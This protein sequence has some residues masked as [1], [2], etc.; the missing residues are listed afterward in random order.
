MIPA[1]VLTLP[2]LRQELE[3]L[4]RREHR[5]KL[6]ALF[7]RGEAAEF[8]LNGQRW[9]VLPTQCELE[10]RESLP[11]PDEEHVEGRVFLVDWTS[12][13]LPLDV[14]CRLAGGRLYHVARDARLAA[15]FGARQVEPGLAG[16]ALA[17][18]YLSGVLPP[19]RKV[20]GLRLTLAA[21]WASLLEGRLR[22][23]ESALGSAGTLL[24]WASFND[25]GP[26]F[27]RLCE[28]DELWRKLRRELTDWLRAT[29]GE[30]TVVVWQSWEQGLAPRLLESLVLLGAARAAGEAYLSGLL[31]GQLSAWLP[32][33]AVAVRGVESVLADEKTLDTALPSERPLLLSTLE[34]SEAL[35]ESAGLGALTVSS[36]RLP[37]G[38]RARERELARATLACVEAPSSDAARTV[39]EA[40]KRLE[41]HT[42]D[43]HLRPEE[44]RSARKNLGRMALWLASRDTGAPAGSR[45]QA[46]VELARAYAE[47]GGYVEW[48]RQQL[49]GLRGA[50]ETLLS[51]AR[52]LELAAAAALR[53][54]HRSFAEAY[55]AWMEARKPSA[56][57]LPIEDIGKHLILPFLEG[58]ERRKLLVVLMDGMSHAVAVQILSRLGNAR[59]WGPIAWRKDRWHGVLPLPPVLAVAPTL[60]PLSRGAFFAGKAD[61]RMGDE[62]TD[63][64]PARW[65]AHRALGK[66]FGDDAPPLFVRRDL[67]SGHELAADLR[68]AI[69]GDCRAVAVVVNAVDEDL[70]SS[71]QVAKDYSLAP[72]LPLEALLTAAEEGERAVLLVSDH[73]HVLGDGALTLEGRLSQARA[74]GARWRALAEGEQPEAEELVLP[75]GS[76]V[77]RGWE[78]VAVLWDPSV[79]NR[80]AKYG[81]H[82]GLSLCE[83]V[84]PALLIAPDWL[85]RVLG[86]DPELVVRPLPTPSW[87][88]LRPPP[89]LRQPAPVVAAEPSGQTKLFAPPPRVAPRAVTPASVPFIQALRRSPV[90]QSQTSGQP[91]A[92]LERVLGWLTILVEADGAVAASEFAVAAGVR[93][94]QVG[95]VV[96]RM[97]ILNADGFAMVEHDHAGKRVLMHRARLAQHYGIKA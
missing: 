94:H 97:G 60:T 81:E 28:S 9:R 74:G 43:T 30:A 53:E 79:L 65:K 47:E 45:W 86:D 46:A 77:P 49:R 89:L 1:P 19:P 52:R 55:V 70:K 67:L 83:A 38:H 35:A 15:L 56:E 84:A 88:E 71:V 91:A 85:E 26:A 34:R 37:G 8:E 10:L 41:A 48:A 72:V 3:R 16:S 54:D 36:T 27:L 13:L 7:G 76:W 23:P 31:S 73:G 93:P 64:D 95:G 18:L 61:A 11:R 78:R 57:L 14:A 44:H 6:V 90:F 4:F 12:E 63:K 50:D 40:L 17:K 2:E 21:A 51:A 59:R 32:K 96:A 29:L 22:L 68:A 5:S 20:Q 24:A 92:E 82:G 39:C 42:L 87:W 58:G 75:K 80:S 66:F 62:S 33:L 69:R 25:G